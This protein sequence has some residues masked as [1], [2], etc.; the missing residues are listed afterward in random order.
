MIGRAVETRSPFVFLAAGFVLGLT[1]MVKVHA[2]GLI[3]ALALAALW[4]RP[5]RGWGTTVRRD[6][7]TRLRESLPWELTEDQHRALREITADMVAP[8]RMHRLLMGDVGTGKTVVALFA[9]LLAVENERTFP[10]LFYRENCA[11][12]ALAEAEI[13]PSF[14][15]TH[16]LSL[17]DVA[18]GYSTFALKEDECLKVV[19]S[20]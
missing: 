3:P 10:L 13:D 7:T 1:M 14:I 18:S 11:D 19:M 4:R 8:D 9:M 17:D 12:M 6:L 2:A 20:P 15:I 16:R 5:D